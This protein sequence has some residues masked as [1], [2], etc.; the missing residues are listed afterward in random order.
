MKYNPISFVYRIFIIPKERKF[1]I[2][3]MIEYF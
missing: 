2:N 1:F 3:K